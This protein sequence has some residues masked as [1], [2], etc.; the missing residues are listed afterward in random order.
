VYSRHLQKHISITVISTTV[1]KNKSDF[2]LLLLNDGLF[3]V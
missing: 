2:N 3:W 1:P